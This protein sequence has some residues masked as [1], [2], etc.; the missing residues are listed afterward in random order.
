MNKQLNTV[1]LVDRT[2]NTGNGHYERCKSLEKVFQNNKGIK[3]IFNNFRDFTS[4]NLEAENCIIDS[5]KINYSLE[6]EIKKKCK[7]LVTIDDADT[8]RKFASDIIINYAPF[9][10]KIFYKNRI[11]SK[12]KLLL[13]SDF[14]FIRDFSPKVNLKIKKNLI[15][16]FI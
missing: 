13:G 5:Y 7:K 9:V 2:K 15:F 11:N 1:F 16:L 10:K 3:Y 6:K 14:N 12:C 8:K 4:N